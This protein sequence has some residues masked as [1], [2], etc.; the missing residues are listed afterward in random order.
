MTRAMTAGEQL[1]AHSIPEP[2]SGCTLWTGALVSGGYGR[3]GIKGKAKLA[4]RVAYE[5][6]FGDIGDLCVCHRCDNPS[7]VNPD[8][9]FLGTMADNVADRD[10]KGRQWNGRGRK[11]L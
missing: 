1:E 6:A 10:K 9:L 5:C 2:N 7:C 3:V 4:H 11:R 8:H